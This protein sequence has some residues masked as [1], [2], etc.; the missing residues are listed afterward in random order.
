MSKLRLPPSPQ[1]VERMK[2]QIITLQKEKAELLAV[3]EEAY[4]ELRVRCFYNPGSHCYDALATVLACSLIGDGWT[5][6]HAALRNLWQG[7]KEE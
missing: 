3:C 1:Q 2:A 4:H 6:A 5:D 7:K